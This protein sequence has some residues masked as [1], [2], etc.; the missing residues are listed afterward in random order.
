MLQESN[1]FSPV[2]TRYE[3]FP[4]V[5]GK[6]VL[7]RHRGKLTEMGGFLDVLD[8]AVLDRAKVDVAP[9]CA[10]WAI[11]ANREEAVGRYRLSL[12]AGRKRW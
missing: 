9:V 1:T 2:Y 12:H 3:D 4:P 6:A 11:T 8:N 10:T 5:F 7:E